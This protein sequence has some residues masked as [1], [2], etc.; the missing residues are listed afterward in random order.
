MNITR[1]F[2]VLSS[3]ATAALALTFAVGLASADNRRAAANHSDRDRVACEH[4]G[5]RDGKHAKRDGKA[6]ARD[7]KRDLRHARHDTRD[8]KRDLRDARRDA[9]DQR[10]VRDRRD[11]DGQRGRR[12]V[13]AGTRPM[14]P[15]AMV[16]APF[17]P[18]K[19]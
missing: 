19:R 10:D 8:A 7:A 1:R 11:N 9:R 5:A 2:R 4:D 6:D 16:A 13:R 12:G 17:G 3:I 18:M 14:R 15:G